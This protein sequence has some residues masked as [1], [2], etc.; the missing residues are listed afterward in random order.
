M[1]E[2]RGS[3]AMIEVYTTVKEPMLDLDETG[4]EER[5]FYKWR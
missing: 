3:N 1:E 5:G 2:M 4:E